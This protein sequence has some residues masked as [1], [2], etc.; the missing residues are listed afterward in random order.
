MNAG[1]QTGSISLPQ[2]PV[3]DPLA[4]RTVTARFEILANEVYRGLPKNFRTLCEDLVIRIRG[5]RH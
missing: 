4:W 2:S 3:A 5:L 1:A